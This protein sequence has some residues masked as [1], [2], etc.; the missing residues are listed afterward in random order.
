MMISGEEI[1]DEM[2]VQMEDYKQQYIELG[3]EIERVGKE[4]QTK[5]DELQQE[6][7]KLANEGNAKLDQL[8][9]KREQISGMHAALF[10]QC[11][12]YNVD[13]KTTEKVATV[14]DV[15][16]SDEVPEKSKAVTMKKKSTA[17][18]ATQSK[19]LSEDEKATLAKIVA[20]ENKVVKDNNGNQ[21]PDYLQSEYNK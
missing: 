5:I 12:K 3:K 18:Q 10:N 6:R 7:Q 8:K 14:S 1:L 19:G 2:K 11:A 9:L 4:Y 20:T 13:A 16:K 21:I 15:T 17:K